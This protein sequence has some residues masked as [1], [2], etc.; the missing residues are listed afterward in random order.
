[1]NTKKTQSLKLIDTYTMFI[2]VQQTEAANKF[3][4][5]KLAWQLS[6]IKEI[7]QKPA[8]KLESQR[9]IIFTTHG[10]IKDS[11][12]G[13]S[14]VSFAAEKIDV[15]TT[16]LDELYQIEVDVTFNSI[17]ISELESCKDLQFPAGA[18]EVF[19]KFNII[20]FPDSIK[21][22]TQEKLVVETM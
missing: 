20:S 10:E 5:F 14:D 16:E 1:M 8:S 21:S 11:S 12:R 19:K 7:L 22:S 15:V 18:F 13:G 9:N 2:A 6:D 3:L 17:N 4:P